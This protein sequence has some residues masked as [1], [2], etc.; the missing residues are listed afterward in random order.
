M[1]ERA[2]GI[3]C[4]IA[5]ASRCL[6]ASCTTTTICSV[7]WS[8]KDCTASCAVS[9]SCADGFML[10]SVT[11]ATPAVLM[12]LL[13]MAPGAAEVDGTVGDGGAALVMQRLGFG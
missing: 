6:P 12:W 9:R 3:G 10:V 11:P 4:A 7:T 2:S 8:T 1:C 5:R 13:L